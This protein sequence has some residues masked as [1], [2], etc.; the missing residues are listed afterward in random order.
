SPI[1]GLTRLS[2]VLAK[3]AASAVRIREILDC[4]EA[5]PDPPSPR[6]VPLLTR[7][8]R[9]H[10][11]SFGYDPHRPVLDGFCLHVQAGETVALIGPKGAGKSRFLYLL[12]RLYDAAAGAFLRD[13]VDIRH[14]R[15]RDMR[16][17][18]AF[19]P[20]DPWLLDATLAEN[21]AFGSRTATRAAVLAA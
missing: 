6:P 5:V 16:E 13:G 15:Q 11:V 1:R 4:A 8:V 12:W 2:S 3:A 20:Q 10:A 19:V 14:C 9:M 18:I 7:D 17:R 21:I